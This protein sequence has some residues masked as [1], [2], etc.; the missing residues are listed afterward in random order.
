MKITIIKLLSLV[1]TV[2]YLTFIVIP[3]AFCLLPL[4]FINHILRILDPEPEQ[5]KHKNGH[6]RR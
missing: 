3:L 5:Q 1:I 6:Q 4:T 2:F